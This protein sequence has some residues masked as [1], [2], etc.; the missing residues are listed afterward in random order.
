VVFV[1]AGVFFLRHHS[2]S[3]VVLVGVIFCVQTIVYVIAVGV[4]PHIDE[5][6]VT[7]WFRGPGARI[8]GPD[9]FLSGHAV[10]RHFGS[11]VEMSLHNGTCPISEFVIDDPRWLILE[12]KIEKITWFSSKKGLSSFEALL[13]ALEC[14]SD[15]SEQHALRGEL[16]RLVDRLRHASACGVPFCCG[17]SDRGVMNDRISSVLQD[18]WI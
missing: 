6:R 2:T 12:G 3:A 15:Y 14:S 10:A 8:R 11:L 18:G 5:M 7:L 16:G 17:L 13:R 1:T 9:T 4:I